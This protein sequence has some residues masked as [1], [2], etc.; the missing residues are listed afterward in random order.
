[1]KNKHVAAL[2][3]LTLLTVAVM[4]G[5]QYVNTQSVLENQMIIG[6]ALDR[7]AVDVASLLEAI[8]GQTEAI[9]LLTDANLEVAS[10]LDAYTKYLL[11][12][13]G[14][15]LETPD[16]DVKFDL[17]L[18]AEHR[19][20]GVLIGV[21]EHAGT[22]TTGGK[23][24]IEDQLGD[25]PN[26][27]AAHNMRLSNSAIAPAA[28]WTG[29]PAE[30]AANNMS[31]ADGAYA[32]T[33]DGVWTITYTYTASGAQS[34]QLFGMHS[35]DGAGNGTLVWADQISSASLIAGDTLTLTATTTV[36]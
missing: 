23:N 32:S 2:T 29:L 25:S 34:V 16:T 33:G 1:M 13:A 12:L 17:H 19:R 6:G 35:G 22:L 7:Q 8:D 5:F 18:K 14:Q 20:D 9:R 31:K 10:E 26:G 30:I 24:W 15:I 28:A 3:V 27:T 4:S 11:Y 36:S 21:S